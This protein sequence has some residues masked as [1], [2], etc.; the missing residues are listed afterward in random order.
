MHLSTGSR[1]LTGLARGEI[2]EKA[3]QLEHLRVI[4]ELQSERRAARWSERSAT[5]AG[6]L[7]G[8]ATRARLVGHP[9]TTTP[10]C[11]PA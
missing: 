8:L 10:D 5:L 11:C 3:R 4:R 2:N 1:L 9:A 7:G 6:I